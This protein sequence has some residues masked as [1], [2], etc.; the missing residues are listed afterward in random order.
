MAALNASYASSV[1]YI[2]S[3]AD[4][5][6][7]ARR[8]QN[9]QENWKRF[10]GLLEK[11]GRPLSQM[12]VVHIA[13][14][15]GKGTTSALC[16]AMLRASGSKV[17]LFTSPHLHSFRER[18]RLHGQLVS[19]E[20]VVA[21]CDEI[22][23]AIEAIGDASPFE[24]LTA[25]ALVCFRNAGIEWAVLET[26]LGGRWDCTNHCEPAVCGI[27]RIGLDHMNVLGSTVAEI[28]GEKA[29]IIK[30]CAPVFAVP[31][32]PEALSVLESAAARAATELQ[33]V[34]DSEPPELPFWISPTHQR[35]NAA[36][37]TAMLSSLAS[38][39]LLPDQPP[40]WLAARN[41]TTWPARFEVLRPQLL[42]GS[43]VLGGSPILV[44]DVA[45]NEPAIAAL[46]RSVDAAWP[47]L[48]VA[49]IFGANS[50]KDV[51]S[52]AKIFAAQPQVRQGVAVV[53]S[54]PKA[55]P[56]QELVRGCVA[57]SIEHAEASG[58]PANS[59][60][61]SASSMTEAVRVAAQSL[62]GNPGKRPRDEEN[63][64][65]GG[66]VLCCG[67]VFVAADMRAALA[68]EEPELFSSVDWVHEQGGEPALL[69]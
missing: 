31:Q 6:G 11:L 42:E 69:M 63:V 8:Y 44:I 29:G 12:Q 61:C 39:G 34:T 36:L 26:G 10:D 13:G 23:P 46:M 14:T 21:A 66:V 18:I 25:L 28:A 27:T 64:E 33:V 57:A 37:A 15:N 40:T 55:R 1:R 4:F 16:E 68:Q 24:K 2:F 62:R 54:H 5:T 19:K 56:A 47:K 45:H 35:L 50:D 30:G 49:I 32:E 43:S 65:P 52:I 17:G 59:S 60:W 22:R 20:A 38:R 67:S 53:S 48:P 51:V 3:N 58:M 9:L 41:E 7:A